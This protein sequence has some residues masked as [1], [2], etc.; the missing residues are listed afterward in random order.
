MYIAHVDLVRQT[1]GIL[2]LD[3]FNA[4]FKLPETYWM[5]TLVDFNRE[6]DNLKMTGMRLF[7]GKFYKYSAL[8]VFPSVRFRKTKD[9]DIN[10]IM[11]E[12]NIEYD[13]FMLRIPKDITMEQ[14]KIM[15]K[16]RDA[17]LQRGSE[18]A[19]NA[20]LYDGS[21]VELA[22]YSEKDFAE[23]T[24]LVQPTIQ[25]QKDTGLLKFL[26]HGRH[27]QV[28]SDVQP[29]LLEYLAQLSPNFA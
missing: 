24:N 4:L 7:P 10:E 25:F 1:K 16:E 3:Y 15:V 9:I 26:W 14:A 28:S 20:V 2:S 13:Q 19:K 8:I 21:G 29:S 23:G 17:I 12:T 27:H 18:R 6:K 11:K 22:V 5:Q